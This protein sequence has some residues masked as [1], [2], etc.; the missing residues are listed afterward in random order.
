M[1]TNPD[2]RTNANGNTS[3]VDGKTVPGKSVKEGKKYIQSIIDQIISRPTAKQN[4]IEGPISSKL[5]SDILGDISGIKDQTINTSASLRSSLLPFSFNISPHKQHGKE[6]GTHMGT[7]E[8][9]SH[10]HKPLMDTVAKG[11]YQTFLPST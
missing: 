2:L 11:I 9:V 4:L 1:A 7:R 8:L 10:V 5:K 6:V 3:E